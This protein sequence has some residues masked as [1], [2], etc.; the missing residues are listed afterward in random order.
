MAMLLSSILRYLTFFKITCGFFIVSDHVS[1]AC[2]FSCLVKNAEF[3]L[4]NWHMCLPV[5]YV[6]MVL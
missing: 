2:V 6:N 5:S 4:Y 1:M 3:Y